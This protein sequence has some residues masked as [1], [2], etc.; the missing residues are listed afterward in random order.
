MKSITSTYYI[1]ML[2]M[3]ITTNIQAQQLPILSEYF[4]SPSLINPAM[5]GW[6]DITAVT[7]TYRH[8]W[9]E[10]QGNPIT[11]NLNF[12]HFSPKYNMAFGGGIMHDQTGPTSFTGISLQYA[13]HLQFKSEK[14]QQEKR[15]RL[16]IGLSLSANQYRL[17]G[18][19]L[20]Y[21]D[22]NDAL[23]INNTGS[24]ILPDAG[25]GVFYYN[26]QYF[27]GLSVPQLISMK[28]K[29]ESDNA[30]SAI[31]RIAHFYLNAGAKI[32]LRDKT[33]STTKKSLKEKAKHLLMPSMWI[34]YAPTSPLNV[35]LN[36]RYLWK[37]TLGIGLGAST[38]GTAI[39][40]IS[41]QLKKRLRLGYAFSMPLSDLSPH[42][43]TN[44]EV[45]LT[46]VFGSGGNGWMFEEA[47]QQ[48]SKKKKEQ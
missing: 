17:Q 22:A 25:L 43:G 31:Q 32:E 10:M 26:D 2:A 15:N 35:H 42:L 23:I 12:R 44:H 21:N 9:A 24:Q 1:G 5:T 39:V 47:P 16:S 45:M 18:D 37:Q 8:Q 3:L 33:Q 38:D 36:I 4:H 19:K 34:K 41:V 20:R 7:A 6:E 48:L 27:V 30:L 13:Y 11:A 46:Y 14:Q 28:V 40:D 29:F